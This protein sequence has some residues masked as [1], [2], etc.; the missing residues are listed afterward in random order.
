MCCWFGQN[1]AI[2]QLREV[3]HHT[4]EMLTKLNREV[5]YLNDNR[6]MVNFITA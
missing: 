2:S 1:N 5:I 6:R 4:S 3:L